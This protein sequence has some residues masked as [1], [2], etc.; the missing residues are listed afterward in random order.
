MKRTLFFCFMAAGLAVAQEKTE[1]VD[2]EARRQS[3]VTLKQHLAMREDRLAE[4]AAEI[5]ERGEATDKKIGR[6]VDMLTNLKDSQSSKRRI[7]DIKGEAIVGLRK[8]LEVYKRERNGIVEKIR[9]DDSAPVAALMKD[10]E[11]IDKLAEKR[12]GQIVALVKSMPGGEDVSKYEQ[13]GSNEYNGVYYEN[14]RISEEWRQNRRDKVESEKERREAQD[15]LKKAIDDLER[16]RDSLKSQLAGDKLNPTEKELFEQEL[17][18]VSMLVDVRKSQLLAVAAPS[19]PAENA[20]SKGEADDLKA[21]FQDARKDIAED[22][23]KTVRL[24]QAAAAVREKINDVKDN[25]AAREK[26]LQENDPEAKK[27]E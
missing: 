15:A 25:L 14:S 3:V 11:N 8:M 2:L 12:V 22:F 10:M 7:S 23:A 24:Y 19:A 1:T 18:H 13:D 27:G 20:A 4:V 6:I 21:L 9:G 16:R 5:R 17:G 26:W